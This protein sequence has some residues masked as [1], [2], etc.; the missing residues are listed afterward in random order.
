MISIF[1]YS[2]KKGKTVFLSSEFG[3]NEMFCEI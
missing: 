2:I 1:F 3:G